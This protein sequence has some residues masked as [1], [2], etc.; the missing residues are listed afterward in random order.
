MELDNGYEERTL[1]MK[2]YTNLFIAFAWESTT[3]YL[4]IQSFDGKFDM[5]GVVTLAL[6]LSFI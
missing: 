5:E 1:S 4:C 6:I 2:K 3:K